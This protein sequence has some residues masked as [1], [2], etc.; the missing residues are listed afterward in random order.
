MQ[1]L[2]IATWIIKKV[3]FALTEEMLTSRTPLIF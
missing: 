2:K 1:I 3:R